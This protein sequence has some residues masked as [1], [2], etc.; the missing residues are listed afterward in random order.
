MVTSIRNCLTIVHA[1]FLYYFF[2]NSS[3][4]S[5]AKSV[6]L[7]DNNL[8]LASSVHLATPTIASNCLT[9]GLN[10]VGFSPSTDDEPANLVDFPTSLRW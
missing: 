6:S 5:A 4:S 3:K 2:F 1:F 10:P 8:T 7:V 9:H